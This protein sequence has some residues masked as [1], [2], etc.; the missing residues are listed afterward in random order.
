VSRVV[1]VKHCFVASRHHTTTNL[2]KSWYNK[3]E[4]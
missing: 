3:K 1:V 2:V 4:K